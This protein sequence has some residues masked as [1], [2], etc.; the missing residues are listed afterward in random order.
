MPRWPP[1]VAIDLLEPLQTLG[2][3]LGRQRLGFDGA[4]EHPTAQEVVEGVH[5]LEQ[6]TYF[7]A[8]LW[9]LGGLDQ[10]LAAPAV[11]PDGREVHIAGLV[12]PGLGANH[13][14]ALAALAEVRSLLGA[15][16]GGQQLFDINNQRET[17]LDTFIKT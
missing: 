4:L 15:H 13:R 11:V 1:L 9:Q 16:T 14:R 17:R 2:Q 6:L 7:P 8:G 5:V 10:L 12:V 3:T